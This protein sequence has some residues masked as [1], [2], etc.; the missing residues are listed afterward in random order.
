MRTPTILRYVSI[1]Y[2]Y[3]QIYLARR[4]KPLHSSAG[5]YP[6]ILAVC[7]QP[8]MNQESLSDLLVMDKGTTAKAVKELELKGCIVRK[9]DQSDRR[10]NRLYP[11]TQGEALRDELD[12]FLLEWKEILWKGFSDS[13]KTQSYDLMMRMAANARSHVVAERDIAATP[14]E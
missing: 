6:F 11:T 9:P 14:S 1:L 13:E 8:G 7:R 2:R 12:V 3:S 4:L 10:T 5:L